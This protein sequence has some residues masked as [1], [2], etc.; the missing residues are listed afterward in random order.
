M[1][2]AVKAGIKKT[3]DDLLANGNLTGKQGLELLAVKKYFESEAKEKAA[4]TLEKL[5]EEATALGSPLSKAYMT[6]L[7]V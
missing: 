7:V 1:T 3:T 4:K 2:D 6:G 5:V